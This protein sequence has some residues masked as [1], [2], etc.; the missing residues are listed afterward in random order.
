MSFEKILAHIKQNDFKFIDLR[1]TDLRGK[2]HHIGMPASEVT[3]SF[4][5]KGQTFDGAFVAGWQP[6]HDSDMVL[7]PD[8]SA[9]TTPDP[10]REQATLILRCNIFDPRTQQIYDRDPR[11]IAQRAEQY[12]IESQIA[13]VAYFGLEPEFFIFDK[14]HWQIDMHHA[15]HKIKAK[16]AS[17]LP[18]PY[19]DLRSAICQNLEKMGLKIERHHP[20]VATADQ[21]EINT[22]FCSLLRKADE[23]QIFKYVVHHT[24]QLYGKTATFMPKPLIGDNGNGMHCHQSLFKKGRNLFSGQ[25][26]E[27][28]SMTALYYIGGL[29]KHARAL[30]AFTNSTTN[31]YKR[32]VPGFEAPTSLAYSV[33]NRSAAI[34]L[35]YTHTAKT[36]RI[37]ARFPDPAT[38]P[39]LGLAAMLMAGLD[40]ICQKI[41]PAKA[42]DENLYQTTRPL[43]RLPMTLS[44]ALAA[45]KADNAFLK[46]GGVFSDLLID[47]YIALKQQEVAKLEQTTHPVEFALYYN[48]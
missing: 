48:L 46:Q 34:R 22:Q 9:L 24:A 38:N 43:S 41:H 44:E 1:F 31:S 3:A 42:I 5:Q 19:Q 13:D 8:L 45:L 26:C 12:L 32:L 25:S 40:G 17:A 2:E 35:P 30:S 28:P 6:V 27:K 18:D 37:E 23:L 10:F 47:S 15:L 36:A 11:L 4:L 16:A 7:R 21:N 39:Y 29:L 33:Y 20:E 14:V